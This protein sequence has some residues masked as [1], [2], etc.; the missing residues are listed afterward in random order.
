MAL[1]DDLLTLA[2]ELVDR[3]PAAPNQAEL[4]RGVA[5]AYYALFHLLV[6]EATDRL[7]H[8]AALRPRFMRA[9]DHKTMK[10]VC[11]EYAS[12][13]ANAA[14]QLVKENVRVPRQVQNIASEFVSLQQARHQADYDL[15]TSVTHAEA[16][17]DVMRAELAFL[18]WAT[19]R[20]DPDADAFL[21]ELLCRGIPKRN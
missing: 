10:A 11:R 1:H 5:T 16:D 4:R 2:R 8:V 21:A 15:S 17:T 3:N 13:S 9:F 20:A 14:G 18:D 7:V 19:V 6:F 12:L